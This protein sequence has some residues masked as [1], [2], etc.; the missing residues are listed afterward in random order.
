MCMQMVSDRFVSTMSE[1]G[2]M[3]LEVRGMEGSSLK[4]VY[5][6]GR[7]MMLVSSSNGLGLG[8]CDYK[9]DANEI[10]SFR[11][12]LSGYRYL[13]EANIAE[14]TAFLNYCWG[15]AN[16]EAQFLALQDL[17]KDWRRTD[18]LNR[19]VPEVTEMLR[20][21]DPEKTY[22]DQLTLVDGEGTLAVPGLTNVVVYSP[23]GQRGFVLIGDLD[24]GVDAKVGDFSYEV[25]PGKQAR[26]HVKQVAML[27]SDAMPTSITTMYITDVESACK[28]A[29]FA[30]KYLKNT[31]AIHT[32]GQHAPSDP[33]LFTKVGA[34]TAR[35]YRLGVNE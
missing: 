2:F 8:G 23:E 14:M 35:D 10:A 28:V 3:E 13:T 21:D 22:R 32:E 25:E 24:S 1:Y 11:D 17:P 6:G 16:L 30:Y 19:Y 20:S 33:K 29:E 27:C 4:A 34:R 15:R 26:A 9:Q 31:D 18:L 12:S 7:D 5:F